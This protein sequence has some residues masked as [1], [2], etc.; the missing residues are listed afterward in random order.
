MKIFIPLETASREILYKVFLSINLAKRG[1]KCYL[2]SKYNINKL[3]QYESDFIYIDKGF[4]KGQSE[5]LYDK[6]LKNNGKII[7]LDEEGAIDFEDGST[8]LGRYSKH[9]FNNSKMI[10]L[11]G[12]EQLKIIK[13]NIFNL[14]NVHVTGHPRFELLKTQYHYLYMKESDR[15]KKKTRRIHFN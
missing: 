10:F 13:K 4:H 1:F 11:W 5:K 7:S 14:K 12:E 2:G 9:L 3:V 8:L 15:I 6:I